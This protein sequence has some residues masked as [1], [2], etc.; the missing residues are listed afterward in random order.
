MTML[1]RLL[2]PG[3]DVD[4]GTS[5]AAGFD[6]PPPTLPA[7]RL[8]TDGGRDIAR[9]DGGTSSTTDETPAGLDDVSDEKLEAADVDIETLKQLPK[10]ELVALLTEILADEGPGAD[11]DDGSS[12]E[13]ASEQTTSSETASDDAADAEADGDADAATDGSEPYQRPAGL[14]LTPGTTMLLQCA[15][16]DDRKGAARRDLLGGSEADSR[17]VLLIQ[18][19][20]MDADELEAI[21]RAAR[22]VKVITIGCSQSVP[23]SV[24]DSVEVVDI[25]NPNDVTRLGILATSTLDDWSALAGEVAVSL[26]PLD[27]LFRYKTVEGTFRFLHI[28]LGK[29]SSGG[30]ITHFFVDPSA[31]DPQD[32]N[33]LKPL[34]DH[35]MTIDDNGV[36]VEGI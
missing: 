19:R 1:K 4:G 24:S 34:F 25:N 18:Y 35:V 15:A 22:R 20:S 28:F 7:G 6:G 23:E 12:D 27:V 10:D 29:L 16:R 14:D 31:S 3:T 8:V 26:D 13:T 21:A 17:N 30:A 33:T 5:G 2:F 36:T 32:I 11:G 9:T